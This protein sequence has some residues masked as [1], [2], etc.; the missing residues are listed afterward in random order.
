MTRNSFLWQKDE[1]ENVC[2]GQILFFATAVVVVVAV[3]V[4]VV[5]QFQQDTVFPRT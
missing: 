5:V 2:Y 1:E 3:A 4:V